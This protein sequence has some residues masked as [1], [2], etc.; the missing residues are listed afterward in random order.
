M[1]Y[2]IDHNI[3]KKK[4]SEILE[5]I[6]CSTYINNRPLINTLKKSKSEADL[7]I[8]DSIESSSRNTYLDK[9]ISNRY[10]NKNQ[11]AISKIF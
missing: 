2:P 11:F 10:L 4:S 6:D 7:L 8:I 1:H 9:P 5:K 3:K